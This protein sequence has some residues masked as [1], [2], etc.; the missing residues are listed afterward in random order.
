MEFL[1]MGGQWDEKK[2]IRL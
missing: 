2:L 1:E